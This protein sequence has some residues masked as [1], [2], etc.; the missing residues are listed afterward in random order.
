MKKTLIAVGVAALFAGMATK[1]SAQVEP[2]RVVALVNGEEIKGSEYYRRMEFLPG[3]GKQMGR[4]F[5]EFPPGFLTLEQLITE[6]LVYQLAKDKGV[7]PTDIEID[8]ELKNRLEID[9]NYVKNWNEAGR[10]LDELKEVIRFEVAQYKVQTFGIT[11]TD[12]EVENHYKSNP[13]Q[14]TTPKQAKLR[15]IVVQSPEARDDVDK[16]LQGGKKFEDVAKESSLDVS[17]VQGGEY[18]TVPISFLTTPVRSAVE[19]TKIGQVTTWVTTTN[20]GKETYL[21]FLLEDILP[22]TKTPL[23]DKVRK[24]IRRRL[25]ADKGAVKN[26]IQKEMMALRSKAKIDI[27]QPEF[28]DAYKKFIG[29]YLKQG[30]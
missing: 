17:K 16:A 18:G 21:K 9:P 3:V 27:K 30:G 1:C 22:E 6:R 15:V 14:F 19:A 23:T 12:Q 8:A 13:E 2:G 11:I 28:A 20:D 7:S 29:A 26:D 24:S 4:G 10:T 5:A 25:M